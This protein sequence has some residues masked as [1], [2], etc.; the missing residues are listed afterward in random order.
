MKES[1]PLRPFQKRFLKEVQS[2]KHDI[3]CLSLAR[4]NGKSFLA[5]EIL[6]PYLDP[7][8]KVFD[9]SK[10]VGLVSSS[11]KT[12]RIVFRYLRENLGEEG[13]TYADSS[14]RLAIKVD[15]YNVRLEVFSSD[16]RRAQGIVN[17]SLIVCDEPA[18]WPPN[19]IMYET[20]ITA[21]GKPNS[22]LRLVFVGTLAPAPPGSWWP[23][24]ISRGSVP[25]TFVQCIACD[26]LDRWDSWAQ[27]RKCNPLVNLPGEEGKRFRQTLLRARD[28]ARRDSRLKSSYISFRL[29]T[30]CGDEST[31]LLTLQDW[32]LVKA[33]PVPPRPASKPCVGIDL[34][35]SRSWHACCAWWPN[36]RVE[37]FAMCGGVPSIEQKEREDLED[38]NVYQRLVDSGHLVID[39]G[40]RAP[41]V[42][43]FVKEI[44]RRWGVPYVVIADL[45]KLEEFKDCH[46]PCPLITRRKRWSE[47]TYD[48]GALRKFASDGPMA[49]QEESRNVVLHS[50]TNSRVKPDESGG[51]RLVKKDKS[52]SRDDIANCLVLAAGAI[53][54]RLSKPQTSSR[55]IR[56]CG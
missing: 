34:G 39:P 26:D 20:L 31:V 28:E 1:L 51:I 30:P 10:E 33:R 7:T 16:A 40:L 38:R 13:Y 50:L 48:I 35:Q 29:N 5:A 37:A 25:G 56:V 4:S 47:S 46:L 44:R 15:D 54:R 43:E 12:C 2:D 9:A 3:C 14:N 55:K 23:N 19:S 53:K 24:L 49:I 18:A 41:R 45:F 42:S 27:A 36:G 6:A 21:L 32:R 11:L 8:S 22:R 17:V 52:T